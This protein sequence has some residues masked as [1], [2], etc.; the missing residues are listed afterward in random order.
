MPSDKRPSLTPAVHGGEPDRFAHDAL[1]API[2]QTA[3]YTFR[4]TAELVE[5]MEGRKER[6][7]YGRYGNPTVSLLEDRV[8]ALEG[9]PAAV[10]FSAALCERPREMALRWPRSRR[11]M[12]VVVSVVLQQSLQG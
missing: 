7:E 1:T 2:F 4:D 11:W 6:E 9:A 3:T 10:A 8:A 12:L 5:Y